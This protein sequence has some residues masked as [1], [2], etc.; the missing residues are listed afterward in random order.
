[1]ALLNP[2]GSTMQVG[3]V[4]PCEFCGRRFGAEAMARHVRVC[5]KNPARK[6][7][8]KASTVSTNASTNNDAK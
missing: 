6:A 3:E 7:N 8:V 1:M 4:T 2:D 5:L